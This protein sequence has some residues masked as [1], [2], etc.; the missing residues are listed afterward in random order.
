MLLMVEKGIRHRMSH[1]VCWYAEVNNNYM[2]DYDQNKEL[3][4]L[5]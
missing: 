5:I 2:R 3:S 4:Y 1:A